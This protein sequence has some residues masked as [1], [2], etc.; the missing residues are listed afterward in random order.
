MKNNLKQNLFSLFSYSILDRIISGF[1]SVVVFTILIRNL[2][3]DEIGLFGLFSG[4]FVFF[5][6]INLSP[7]TIIIR[8]FNKIRDIGKEMGNFILFNLY[9]T[10]IFL[11]IGSGLSLIYFYSGYSSKIFLF[12]LYVLLFSLMNF[13][14][15]AIEGLFASFNQKIVFLSNFLIYSFQVAFYFLLMPHF[16]TLIFYLLAQSIIIFLYTII[17]FSMFFKKNK[18]KLIIKPDW[19]EFFHK[20]IMDFSLWN[21]FNG[22]VTFL[23]YKIDTFVLSFFTT[24]EGL[25]S[26]TIALTFSNYFFI[27]PQIGEKSLR[28]GFSRVETKNEEKKLGFWG[29]FVLDTISILQLVVFF[30]W[31]KPLIR[32]MFPTADYKT[33]YNLS[34]LII[35]GITILNFARPISA[36]LFVKTRMRDLF[37]KVYLPSGIFSILTY[38]I[39]AKLFGTVGVASGNILSYLFFALLIVIYEHFFNERNK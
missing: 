12:P 10:I 7:V 16:K 27:I 17:L 34:A 3:K 26:Y 22:A 8:D 32:F 20:N 38:F 31:G 11:I 35:L 24:V 15:I 29:A 18:I 36:H 37:L 33:V 19:K 28:I 2:P 39:M 25:A 9:K 13:A 1:L 4:I 5:N 30:F 6:F 21:H 23:I 14:S